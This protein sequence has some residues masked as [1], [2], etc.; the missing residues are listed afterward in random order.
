[1]KQKI[2]ISIDKET[3]N[4]IERTINEKIFRNKSHIIEYSVNKV[5][6]EKEQNA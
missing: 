3:A 6:R 5:L 1:M 4:L 2:S